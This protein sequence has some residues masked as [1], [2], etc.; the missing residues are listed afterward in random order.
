MGDSFV[1]LHTHTEYSMLDGAS[2]VDE[3]MRHA[4]QQGMPALAM[5]DHGNMFGAIDFYKA[6][7]EHGVKP[8]I[9]SEL[10]MARGSRYEKGPRRG[11]SGEATAGSGKQESYHHLSVLAENN[12]GYKNLMKLVSRGYLEGYWYKPRAD[13]ELLEQYAD[14]LIVLSGCLGAE[15][16]QHLLSGDER[17][18]RETAAWYRDVL[19]PDN[20][21]IE[22]Q[23]HGIPEQHKTNGQLIEIARDLGLGLVVTNDS[24]YT[25]QHDHEAHDCLLCIQ[26]GSQKSDP[27]RF[28][29]K[30][31]QFYVKA[32]H[33]MQALFPELPQTWKNTLAIAERCNVEI[34]FGTFHLPK[35]EVPEGLTEAEHLRRKV[36]EGAE[37]RYGVPLSQKVT[38]RLES[39]LAI[40]E[41]MGFPAYFLIVADLCE[42]ARQHGIR[43]G[44]GRG[45]AAGCAVAYCTG[46]TDLDPIEHDLIFERFLN[47]ERVTMPDIDL[48]FDERRRGEMIQYSIDKYGEDRVAQIIT[49]STIKAK[50]AIRDAARVMG[51][52]FGFGDRLSKM[53]PPPVMGKE[54]ALDQAYELSTELAEAWDN[55]PD[56]KQVLDTAK[57]L[58]GLRRQHSIHAAGVVIAGDPITEHCP[59][60]RVEEGEVVTQY[61]GGM[62]EDIG[63]LKMDFLGLRNLTVISDALAHIE[64]TTGQRIDIDH[65][66]LDDP[67]TYE[68]LSRGDTDG[69]F[70]LDSTGIKALCKQLKPDGF[71]D[72]VALLALYRP[73]PMSADL[74]TEYVERKHGRKPVTYP[75]DDLVEILEPTYGIIVYQ[76]QVLKIAQTLAGFSLGEADLLRRAIGK[77]KQKE[78]DAQREKFLAGM[79]ER[80][81]SEQLAQELWDLIEGF[82][83]YA[84]NKSHSAGYGL[85]SYQTAYL[86]AHYPVEYMSALLTSVKTNKDRLPLYLHTCRTMG[87]EVLQPDVNDSLVDFSPATEPGAEEGA[88]AQRI[89]FGL[90][91]VR[92]V[93]ESVCEAIIAARREH[94]PFVDF[95]D[96]CRKVDSGVLNKRTLE[97]LIKAG[98][99][100]SLGHPRKGLLLA[101]EPVVEQA[102]SIKRNEAMGQDSLF[103]DLGDEHLDDL[104]SL[105]VDDAE[106]DRKEKLAHEREMLGLYV[107]DHPLFGLERVIEQ[108]STVA[109]GELARDGESA[110]TGADRGRSDKQS[111]AGAAQ[112]TVA[113]ILTGLAKKFTKKGEPYVTGTLED[114]QG[115]I[116]CIFFPSVYADAAELLVEDAILAV[117]GRLDGADPPKVIATDVRAPDVSDATRAPVELRVAPE[118]CTDTR[119]GQLKRVL[120]E[121][122]GAAPVH[123]RLENGGARRTTLQLPDELRVSRDGGLYAQLK[124]LLGPDAIR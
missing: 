85:V 116:D 80:G 110:P 20:Y 22:L 38:E 27:D 29:F 49:Y 12:T 50:A 44:P 11:G 26:T 53:M 76:E 104:G 107:S 105:A 3:I 33:E 108:Q 114:L 7:L 23:D 25:H 51:H 123:L 121:H 4:A 96:F 55:E 34:D 59:V 67:A 8:I 14:G 81:Y 91:G 77:K 19:G 5:T 16:N 40:I 89:R 115:G 111:A 86:K 120:A 90:S 2:R 70:Q 57:Q 66:P 119:V 68:M 102:Q 117:S 72:V 95:G 84:F 92:N 37:Q 58:E 54:Y 101:Y 21:F 24:H 71:D 13:K 52:P 78:M 97:S 35:F 93:G 113:G 6:G 87:I 64:S 39:E 60:L 15:V 56:A 88:G 122:P 32:P 65:V 47:P 46:I 103:G 45:S 118:Q 109:I 74:H 106:F 79:G 112:L 18:A 28:K 17:A 124:S 69:V 62:V 43:L 1:H 82:A 73:G 48:D 83:D 63:L 10:Y 30:S 36:F 9:G 31:D 75:H 61:D 100:E 41:Q 94:G 98:A 99:F 42:Y